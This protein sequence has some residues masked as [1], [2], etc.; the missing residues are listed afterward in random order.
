MLIKGRTGFLAERAGTG[1]LEFSKGSKANIRI[2]NRAEVAL[3][4]RVL[5]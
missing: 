3:G 4:G 5:S 1:W 2:K